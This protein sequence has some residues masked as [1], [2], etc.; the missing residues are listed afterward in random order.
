MV[1]IVLIKLDLLVKCTKNLVCHVKLHVSSSPSYRILNQLSRAVPL[2]LL[3]AAKLLF[4]GLFFSQINSLAW[5]TFP[6]TNSCLSTVKSDRLEARATSWASSP[7]SCLGVNG[8]QRSSQSVLWTSLSGL[9]A[10]IVLLSLPREG[11]AS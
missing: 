8:C 4:F 5:F 9:K 11:P 7:S 2:A 3:A 6:L 10:F 1:L